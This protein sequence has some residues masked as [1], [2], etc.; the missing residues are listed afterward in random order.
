MYVPHVVWSSVAW[1]GVVCGMVSLL[2]PLQVVGFTTEQLVCNPSLFCYRL[3]G[4]TMAR[5]MIM[6][7][8]SA[9]LRM[10]C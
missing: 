3:D 9:C 10:E 8:V 5:K 2:I 6:D 4:R 7:K 1:C